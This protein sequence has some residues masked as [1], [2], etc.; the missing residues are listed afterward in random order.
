M[1]GHDI[2]SRPLFPADSSF[3]EPATGEFPGAAAS[4]TDNVLAM[5]R[6]WVR[7][8]PAAV[9]VTDGERTLSYADLDAMSGR[10]AEHLRL[11]GAARGSL[12]AIHLPRSAAIVVAALAVLKTGAAYVPLDDDLPP[13]R[14]RHILGDSGA[15]LV[16]AP[17]DVP[18]ATLLTGTAA[19]VPWPADGTGAQD[20]ADSGAETIP[21]VS[22]APASEHD[23][24]AYVIYTSGSTGRPKGVQIDHGSLT[25]LLR[26]ALGVLP[27][28]APGAVWSMAHSFSFD[29][30]VWEMWGCLCSGGRLVVVPRAVVRDPAEFAAL[31]VREKVTD[32]SC[33]PSAFRQLS[34]RLLESRHEASLRHIVFGGEALTPS[35]VAPW[36]RAEVPAT[37]LINMY[38]ITEITVHGTHRLLSERDLLDAGRSVIGSPLPGYTTRVVREGTVTEVPAGEAGELLVGGRGVARGYLNRPELTAERFVQVPCDGGTERM[39]RSGDLV[40]RLPDGGLEYLG[41]IDRQ[42]KLRGFRIELGEIEAA[43][44]R[45][46]AVSAAVAAVWTSPSDAHDQRLVAWVVPTAPDASPTHRR[47]AAYLADR[48][49]QHMI[50]ALHLAVDHIPLTA[51]GKADSSRLPDPGPML[52]AGHPTDSSGAGAPAGSGDG[53]GTAAEHTLL[54]VVRSVLGDRDHRLSDTFF[55]AGGDSLTAIRVV[56]ELGEH[57]YTL[58][59]TDFFRSTSLRDT[60][61]LLRPAAGP[62]REAPAPFSLLPPGDQAALPEG[63]EDAYPA[64]MLQEGMLFEIRRSPQALPYHVCSSTALD[65]AVRPE[66]ARNAV[67]ELTRAH[68]VLRTS[69]V[70]GSSGGTVRRVHREARIAVDFVDWSSYDAAETERALHAFVE[71]ESLRPIDHSLAPL[72][73]F[74]FFRT[75]AGDWAA[76][77][78]PHTVLDGWS[79]ARLVQDL[80]GRLGGQPVP[81]APDLA[82]RHLVLENA[83][84]GGESKEFWAAALAGATSER[85]PVRHRTAAGRH[86]E[87]WFALPEG[88]GEQLVATSRKLDIPLKSLYFAAHMRLAHHWT[89]SGAPVVSGLV[90]NGRPEVTEAT[91]ATGLFLNTVP[92]VLPELPQ[93]WAALAGRLFDLETQ[94]L[95]HRRTPLPVIRSCAPGPLHPDLSFNYVD[96]ASTGAP[97]VPSPESS[98]TETPCC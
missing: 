80:R 66:E 38:G 33:T 68:P 75:G 82:P 5:L 4:E 69:F 72:C 30:S 34:P 87:T 64:T 97:S 65:R 92:V 60:A 54:A 11:R 40:R 21:S 15:D 46:P 20:A 26:G 43:L 18:A 25:H 70:T 76:I 9:A 62:R 39:Y 27:A 59:L 71:A 67:T 13:E 79:V 19:L 84:C 77:T 63:L 6:H 45:H 55:A 57:G 36:L 29:F 91:A 23:D 61:R 88:L 41:R 44:T 2:E 85:M 56:A 17:P 8:T 12:V 86:S 16:L 37:H 81:T 74:T 94:L 3:E 48:L 1:T 90:C 14:L 35:D 24:L 22:A 10:L 31:L 95:P 89:A 93:S 73:T 7:T 49:P 78:H 98:R 96:F 53:P 52:S 32:L 58:N 47:L 83:A 50:P 28:R 51:N 42:V